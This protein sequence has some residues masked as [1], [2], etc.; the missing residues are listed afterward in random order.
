MRIAFISDIHSNYSA[1]SSVLNKIDALDCSQ[2]ICLGDMLGYYDAPNSVIDALKMKNVKCIK[3]NHDKYILGE[4]T[5]ED[6][7]K[8]IYGIDRH[9]AE[10]TKDNYL[11]LKACASYLSF[12]VEEVKIIC[13]HAIPND[14]TI[15]LNDA[16]D[17]S[18]YHEVITECDMYFHGHTH[19][20]QELIYDNT[21]IVN[22][23]S[24]GQPRSG[25]YKASFCT[26]DFPEKRIQW[27]SVDYDVE[28]YKQF[29][30]ENKYDKMVIDIFDRV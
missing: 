20:R 21:I 19:R 25:G 28:T 2:I 26:V 23:G 12:N 30:K 14:E 10:L 6:K 11:Y 17:Y 1:L 13:A 3:G 5:F 4:L 22:P 7:N 24:V 29:L 8:E 15:Y 18:K 9:R 16:I 27:Y